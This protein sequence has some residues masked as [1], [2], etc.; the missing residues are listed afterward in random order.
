MSAIKQ[1]LDLF[2]QHRDLIDSNSATAINSLRKE[3]FD[4]LSTTPLPKA[5]S[6]NYENFDAE[7]ML[8]PDYGLNIA[9]LEIDVNPAASF[10]CDVPKLS[11]HPF[12][13]INDTFSSS[14]CE[15][16]SLP[17]GVEVGSLREFAEKDTRTFGKY[18]GKAADM[19]NLM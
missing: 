2:S 5:G 13:V 11:A 7:K 10:H 15:A 1:Y 8:A 19:S 12:F 16:E 17:E 9:R 14:L 3:A 18:Y 4:I 6:D